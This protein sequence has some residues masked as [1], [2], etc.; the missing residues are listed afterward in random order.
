MIDKNLLQLL[1]GNRKYIVYTIALMVLGLLSNVAVTAAICWAISIAVRYDVCS[2]G[3]VNFL[4]P[5]LCALAGI[6]VRYA[7][8]RLVGDL[9]DT[10]GR[11]AK[12]ISANA[13]MTR[14][15]G[16]AFAPQT[17]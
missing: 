16:S 9:K 8:T 10:L 12:R 13:C 7:A 1:G 3:A 6:T 14:S 4:W 15:S 11:K 2:G 5:A 17:A